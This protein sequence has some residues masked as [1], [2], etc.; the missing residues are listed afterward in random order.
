MWWMK[1]AYFFKV[2]HISFLYLFL[3]NKWIENQIDRLDYVLRRICNI[4]AK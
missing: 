3:L 2:A 1:R 4:S